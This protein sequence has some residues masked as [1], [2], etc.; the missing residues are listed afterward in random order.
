MKL[1]TVALVCLLLAGM[2]LQDVNSK[3]KERRIAAKPEPG[4]IRYICYIPS[5][6]HWCLG[7]PPA[8]KLTTTWAYP[9]TAAN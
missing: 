1:I 9:L 3:S 2:W 8:V 5:A 6:V 4:Y 7:A